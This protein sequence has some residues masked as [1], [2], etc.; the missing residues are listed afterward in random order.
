MD[1]LA[2]LCNLHADGPLSLRRLRNAGV[3]TLREL[4]GVPES[5][6]SAILK[7]SPALARRLV[8]EARQLA[9][10]LD[11]MPLE[12]DTG[13]PPEPAL[14]RPRPVAPVRPV[15][16]VESV[17]SVDFTPEPEPEA[18]APSAPEP[19]LPFAEPRVP[20]AWDLPGHEPEPVSTAET[21]R[22]LTLA[23]EELLSAP[24][25]GTPAPPPAPLRGDEQLRR[26]GLPGL[27]RRVC[28]RLVREGV[29]T[30]RDLAD[31]ASLSL[32]RRAGIPY[33]RLL[34]LGLA[35]RVRLRA[36]AAAGDVRTAVDEE[37]AEDL[38]VVELTPPGRRPP[39][40]YRPGP[41]LAGTRLIGSSQPAA[42]EAPPRP[43]APVVPAPPARPAPEVREDPGVAGPFV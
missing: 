4:T 15:V 28:E 26:D 41:V 34:D 16:P 5:S 7:A 19:A 40:S 11:E 3:R 10:R 18:D 37:L 23:E 21:V 24:L 6:L 42:E 29:R 20:L 39:G 25:E 32:A 36:S 43:E 13:S 2:L 17:E 14:P 9:Q 27:D 30:Y 33:P 8:H 12:P 22:P 1:G 31:L 35:A 38:R